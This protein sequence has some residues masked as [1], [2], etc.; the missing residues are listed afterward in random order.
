MSVFVIFPMTPTVEDSPC[1]KDKL[2]ECTM[3]LKN[4]VVM[5]RFF[6]A[7]KPRVLCQQMLNARKVSICCCVV[8]LRLR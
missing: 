7:E 2:T 3:E 8:V 6:R 5:A 4:T 1:V